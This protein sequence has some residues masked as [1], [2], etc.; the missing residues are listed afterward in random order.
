MCRFS[1]IPTKIPKGVFYRTSTNNPKTY[2]EERKGGI[3]WGGKGGK[4]EE[5]KKG[6]GK[7]GVSCLAEI[8]IFKDKIQ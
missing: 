1:G 6:R 5:K 4:K 8:N 2:M 7:G 3:T